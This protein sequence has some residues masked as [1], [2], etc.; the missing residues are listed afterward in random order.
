MNMPKNNYTVLVCDD[1][2]DIT[3]ALDIY[4]S[5]EGYTVIRSANGAEALEVIAKQT[6]H[7]VLLD[8]MMPVM[9]GIQ[10]AIKIRESSNVP[11]IFL[12]AKGEEADKVLGLHVGG[13]DYIIKPFTPMELFARTRS[14]IRRYS[15]LGG[16][17][18]HETEG[19]Y[20]TGD[21]LLDSKKK[22]VSV[23]GA[24]VTLTALE[25]N[26]L[27]LLISHPDQVFSSE[28]IYEA[29][30]QEPAYDVRRIISVHISHIREK[31][32]V[33]PKEPR[34]LKLA[35]GLGYKVVSLP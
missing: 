29:V 32:E 10:T 5:G 27:E 3:A 23:D 6:V 20:I 17:P 22:I 28:Q 35:Y 24:P 7:L 15:Q 21:L 13:D 16:M 2:A 26:I 25:F 1:D 19:V 31:I 8:V 34:Y 9:D 18:A 11:I 14:A 33:N 12:S 30:R 4:L